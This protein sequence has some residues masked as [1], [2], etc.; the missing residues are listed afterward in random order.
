[1]RYEGYTSRE[2]VDDILDKIS[3]YGM[4]SLT[5]LEK[6]FL[7]LFTRAKITGKDMIWNVETDDV[8]YIEEIERFFKHKLP[9]SKSTFFRIVLAGAKV[10]N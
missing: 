5:S 10:K 4:K 8:Q 1:M 7:N 2:R 6:E 9:G 3:K